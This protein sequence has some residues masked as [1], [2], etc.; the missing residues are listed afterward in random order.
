MVLGFYR[1][2]VLR[3]YIYSVTAC[4]DGII[5]GLY[6]DL[7]CYETKRPSSSFSFPTTIRHQIV[8]KL[9]SSKLSSQQAV[10][11]KTTNYLIFLHIVSQ[12][13]FHFFILDL[14][15]EIKKY[16]F[17]RLELKGFFDTRADF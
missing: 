4:D 3:F 10:N 2:M 16:A 6:H 7:R 1:S 11:T 5:I 9:T 15:S 17:Y 13:L 8:I 14:E 12:F